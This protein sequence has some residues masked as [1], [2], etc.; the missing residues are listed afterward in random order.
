MKS[1]KLSRRFSRTIEEP[2]IRVSVLEPTHIDV[3]QVRP[4]C[5]LTRG[6]LY[7]L[8]KEGVIK[9]VVVIGKDRNGKLRSRGKRLVSVAS[10]KAYLARLEEEGIG[11]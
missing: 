10:L 2:E 6:V 4:Y 7:P 9:S 8:L 1:Q 3:N 5:G 11:A